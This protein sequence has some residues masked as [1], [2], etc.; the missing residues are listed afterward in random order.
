MNT[1]SVKRQR[2][3]Q[4]PIGMHCDTLKWVPDPFASAMAS[5]KTSKLPLPLGVFIPLAFL[6]ISIKLSN[7][8]RISRSEESLRW[9]GSISPR[10]GVNLTSHKIIFSI[11][12]SKTSQNFVDITYLSFKKI[13]LNAKHIF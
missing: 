13:F 1:P 6:S 3:W 5:V 4:G 12:R 11:L 10:F 2:Q 8:L 7:T 9:L